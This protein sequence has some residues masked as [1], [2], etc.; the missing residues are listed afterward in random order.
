ML[1]LAVY[2]GMP[3]EEYWHGDPCLLSNYI[4]A[5]NKRRQEALYDAWLTGAYFKKALETTIQC[6]APILSKP[7]KLGEY[8]DA[9]DFRS[10]KEKEQ[11]IT[12][13]E[14]IAFQHK[15][16]MHYMS[17]VNQNKK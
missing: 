1:D 4:E 12:Q 11:A 14:K 16:Y 15:I 13:Q 9:P 3:I 8:P 10:K 7:P 5:H 17:L 6:S 2:V